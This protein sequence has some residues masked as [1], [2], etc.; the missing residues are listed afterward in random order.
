MKRDIVVFP[1]ILAVLDQSNNWIDIFSTKNNS[2][3]R[4]GGINDSSLE[5]HIMSTDRTIDR[6][7]THNDFT[8]P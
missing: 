3:F 6:N 1:L 2:L 8:V 4:C 5:S 7:A